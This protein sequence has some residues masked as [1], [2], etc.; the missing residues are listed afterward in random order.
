MVKRKTFRQ[1]V[2]ATP[3]VSHCYRQGKQAIKND[4]RGKVEMTDSRKCGGSLFID[5][6]LVD[7]NKY[8]QENRWDYAIDYNGKSVFLRSSQC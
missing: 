7:Q 1:A 5:Q 4:E 8:S 6:C 2:E 3:D